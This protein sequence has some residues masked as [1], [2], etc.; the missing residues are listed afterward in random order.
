MSQKK[1]RRGTVRSREEA[2]TRAL[3]ERCSEK[4]TRRRI[5]IRKGRNLVK[6]DDTVAVITVAASSTAAITA[7]EAAD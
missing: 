1:E 7:A 5:S 6:S 4:K 2:A 3:N